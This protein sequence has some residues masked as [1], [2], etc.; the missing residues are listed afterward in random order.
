M[1]SRCVTSPVI[2]LTLS[3]LWCLS[4]DTWE[5]AEVVTRILDLKIL[6]NYNSKNLS[7]S[8]RIPVC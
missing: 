7:L 1:E 5:A 2:P 8:L 3:F 4:L 6:E